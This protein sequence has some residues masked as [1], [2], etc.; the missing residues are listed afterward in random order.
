MDIK[1]IQFTNDDLIELF[2]LARSATEKTLDPESDLYIWFH[3]ES[4]IKNAYNKEE[5]NDD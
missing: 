2:E 3:D 5:S 1:D 4:N